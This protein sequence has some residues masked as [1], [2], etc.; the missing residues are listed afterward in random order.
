MHMPTLLVIV[1]IAALLACVVFV[2]FYHKYDTSR[3]LFLDLNL[4]IE[5]L[6]GIGGNIISL[7]KDQNQNIV[8]IVS[9]K[10][11]LDVKS[12]NI[13]KG[14]NPVNF[15]ANF[16]MQKVDGTSS[17]KASLSNYTLVKSNILDEVATLDG[18]ASLVNTGNA[19]SSDNVTGQNRTIPL[20]I[21]I[22][23][24]RTISI[25]SDSE[26]FHNYFASTPV[27]GNVPSRD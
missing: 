20:Q 9:G 1:P 25:S 22:S 3:N 10:W 5:D 12:G 11:N 17:A 27:Y 8:W 26:L 4:S 7:Q 21:I 15:G 13:S 23:N 24:G 14:S 6:S 19:L 16:S 18:T 2:T